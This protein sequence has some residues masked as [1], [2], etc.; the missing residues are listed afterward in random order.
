MLGMFANYF[1]FDVSSSNLKNA[2]KKIREEAGS[3]MLRL[4]G[5]AGCH[6]HVY[7]PDDPARVCPKI[8]PDGTGCG[9]PRYDVKGSPHEVINVLIMILFVVNFFMCILQTVFYFSLRN[10]LKKLLSLPSY[11]ACCEHEFER[12]RMRKDENMI[13]D[14][15]DSDG[16]KQFM[17]PAVQP[18]N[19][20]GESFV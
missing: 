3:C 1:G 11:R 17:G 5:C 2:D 8:K 10:R 14:V 18:N 15:Y 9:H 6:Q 7:L 4:N 16:W 12:Q 19:R 20:L 13:S